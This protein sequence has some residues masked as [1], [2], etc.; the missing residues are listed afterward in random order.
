[1][2][3]EDIYSDVTVTPSADSYG[4]S[5]S[6]NTNYDGSDL[7]IGRQSSGGGNIRRI[8]IKWDDL[9]TQVPVGSKI[10]CPRR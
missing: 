8:Y 1:M 3:G 5:R 10:I 6:A 9:T 2:A 4:S 7:E